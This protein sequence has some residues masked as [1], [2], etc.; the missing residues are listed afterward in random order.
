MIPSV[1]QIG[2]GLA[3]L[4]GFLG[5][6]ATRFQRHEAPQNAAALTYTTLLSLVPLMTVTL[7]VFSAFPVAD[8]VYQAVQD[9][10]FQ[11]FVPTS[12]EVLQQYL[13]EFSAKASRL[14][15]TGAAFLVVVA[16]LMMSNIDRAL[17]AIWEVKTQR[18]FASKFLIYW[19]VLSL[20][21]ILIGVSFVVTSYVVSLPIMSEA[22]STGFG[23]RVLGLMPVVASAVAFTMMYAVVPNRRVRF[24]HALAGGVFA[25]VLF[26][27]AKRGFGFYITQFPTY[28]AIYGA[29]AT[30]PIFLVW[31]YLSWVVVLL[32][33]EVTHC[34]SIYRWGARDQSRI[35]VG[36]GDAIAVLLALDEASA[37]GVAPTTAQLAASSRRWMEPQLE[38]LLTQLRHLHWVHMTRDGGWTLARQLSDA[39]LGA[40]YR[41]REFNLP[42]ASDPDWPE[43]TALADVLASANAGLAGALDVPLAT[44]RQ[45]RAQTHSIRPGNP[46]ARESS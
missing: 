19:A 8:R 38:D 10:V 39:T 15:G 16:L 9:F 35:R 31:L 14:T 6:V 18:S 27:V 34:L 29:L 5:L 13:S 7:A 36:M 37:R 25:A 12:S 21:P 33:A 4:R 30:I 41:S 42:E 2:V 44:F 24:A 11:N 23:R 40:L 20:G 22:T 1:Q 3:C 46:V 32:G 26:E 28:E 17:N 45:Q 43:N